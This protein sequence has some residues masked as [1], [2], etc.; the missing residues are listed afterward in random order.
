[1]NER[2]RDVLLINIWDYIQRIEKDVKAIKAKV[3]SI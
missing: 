2:E 1:M 3:G